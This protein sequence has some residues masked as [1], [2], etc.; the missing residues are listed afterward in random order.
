MP[1]EQSSTVA[2]VPPRCRLCKT[3]Y[4]QPAKNWTSIRSLFSRRRS[5]KSRPHLRRLSQAI[6]ETM[7]RRRQFSRRSARRLPRDFQQNRTPR[8]RKARPELSR[9]RRLTLLNRQRH[10]AMFKDCSRKLA[11]TSEQKTPSIQKTS[12][13]D[14]PAAE[15]SK[16]EP[17]NSG[18]G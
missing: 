13:D 9:L 11:N 15:L 7:L 4:Q 18:R 10:S 3:G 5:R 16:S 8:A 2:T 14:S 1:E 12:T 17:Q 6:H